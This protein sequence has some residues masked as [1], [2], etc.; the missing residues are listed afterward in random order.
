MVWKDDILHAVISVVTM[1]KP[2]DYCFR[3]NE[4]YEWEQLLKTCHP[5]NNNI[6]AKIRQGLQQLRD[7][8]IVKF[9]SPGVYELD[10]QYIDNLKA[11]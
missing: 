2:G 7:K 1:N 5:E 11:E 6:K 3:L 10:K 8:G 4:I 9:L